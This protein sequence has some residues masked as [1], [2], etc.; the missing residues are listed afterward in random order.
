MRRQR[1]FN[2][3]PEVNPDTYIITINDEAVIRI[4]GPED[5]AKAIMALPLL[6]SHSAI[7]A[8]KVQTV[9]QNAGPLLNGHRVILNDAVDKLFEALT[10]AGRIQPVTVDMKAGG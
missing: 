7:A 5:L 1:P 6:L 10:E 4:V 2:P 8:Y 9:L 3:R